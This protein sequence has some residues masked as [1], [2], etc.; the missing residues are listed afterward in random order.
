MSKKDA[1]KADG[2]GVT[3]HADQHDGSAQADDKPNGPEGLS[4]QGLMVH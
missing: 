2:I 3:S 4:F 1:E